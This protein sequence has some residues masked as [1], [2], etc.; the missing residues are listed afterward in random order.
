MSLS[1]STGHFKAVLRYFKI[2]SLLRALHIFSQYDFL[3]HFTQ[4]QSPEIHSRSP[5]FNQI[6]IL[7]LKKRY[8]STVQTE[9]ERTNI[10]PGFW[11]LN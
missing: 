3:G 6:Q 2:R 7:C 8:V 9:F 11:Q 1:E 4:G 5:T 10:V